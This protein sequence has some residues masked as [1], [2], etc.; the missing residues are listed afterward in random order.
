MSAR[1]MAMAAMGLLGLTAAVRAADTA[2]PDVDATRRVVAAVVAE[3]NRLARIGIARRG[4]DLTDYYIRAAA[5][6]ARRLP[7]DKAVPAF[8]ASLGIALDDS[9]TVRG[10][11]FFGP[12]CRR[13]ES[14]ADR[15]DRL[16]VLGGPSLR[17]RRDWCQ[18]FAV[19]CTLTAL[20]GPTAAETAG[21]LKERL[22]MGSGGSGFSFADLMAD[23]AGVAFAVRLRE[24]TLAL[25]AVAERFVGDEFLPDARGLREGLTAKQF[26]EQYGGTTD[27]R[28]RK[29]TESIRRRIR[30]LSGPEKK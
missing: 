16:R 21:L 11:R 13:V 27:E 14:D 5:A 18:H 1:T 19:S 4:D 17:H 26:A 15:E 8:L 3:A 12:F 23:Y 25:D 20:A 10:N 28:F 24:G 29:E 7:H 9:T 6:E 2:L 30:E 22:D